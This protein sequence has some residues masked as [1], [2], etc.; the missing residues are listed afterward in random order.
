MLVRLMYDCIALVI[1]LLICISVV[2]KKIYKGHENVAYL[3]MVLIGIL[4]T[5]FDILMEV[6]Y[7][8][9]PIPFGRLLFAHVAS[10]GYLLLR[11]LTNLAY[12][13]LIFVVSGTTHKLQ[14]WWKKA[15]FVGPFFGLCLW[16]L[17]NLTTHQI[18]Q[19]TSAEGYS[20][21]SQ[22]P[23]LYIFTFGYA[24][25]GFF[26]LCRMRR[27]L[28]N[29]KYFALI[30][31]Y[32]LLFATAIYQML[33]PG[34]L[35]EMLGCSIA[36]LLVH[37]LVQSSDTTFPEANGLYGWE[38][39]KL[40]LARIMEVKRN[41]TI[42]IVR[43]IN[44]SEMRSSYGEERYNQYVLQKAREMKA[45]LDK[46]IRDYKVFYHT[47][48]SLHVVFGYGEIDVERSFPE[49][50]ALWKD[51][52]EEGYGDKIRPV[53]CALEF[54]DERFESV[55]SLLNFGFL[56]PH[57][58]EPGKNFVEGERVFGSKHYELNRD[59]AQVLNRGIRENLFEMYYQPIYDV[60]THKFHSAEAL[61]R[62]NDSQYGFVPPTIFIPA[63]ERR[64]MIRPIGKFVLDNVF[65]FAA[66]PDFS[67]LGLKYVE[68]NLSVEQLLQPGLE[69]EIRQLVEK[70][71]TPPERIN[72]EITESVAGLQSELGMRNILA[73]KDKG[74]SFSIDDYGTGYSNVQRSVM[75]PLSI[76]KIDKSIIDTIESNRGTSI[77]ANTIRMMHDVGF[78]IVAEGVETQEQV[79]EL[80]K[81]NCDYIQG[82]YFA[83]PMPLEDFLVFLKEKNS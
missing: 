31:N 24:L 33:H 81:L 45:I 73:L 8:H 64:N 71:G 15:L 80:E 14:I 58:I 48:G 83:K 50:L 37:L 13:W 69:E 78:K 54:P 35:I 46:R 5:V 66:R 16:V 20:R 32:L 53:L 41:S 40:Q 67:F 22:M 62:L 74:F 28:G 55:E 61:I 44:A 70:H 30:S 42:L 17:S 68:L 27:Y 9:L 49:L 38:D 79:R 21:G 2:L 34:V 26:Y 1:Y 12:I 43:M 18:F 10:Y 65:A 59:M 56:F 29:T 72:L 77:I 60:K 36:L 82:F 23:I 75:L 51:P 11:Q 57:Y 63:A 4:T 76:V 3:R 39:L 19:I 6:S 25:F 47:S 7:T 52:G